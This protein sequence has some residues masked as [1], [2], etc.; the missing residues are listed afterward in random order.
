MDRV[1]LGKLIKIERIKKDMS[2]EEL[3]ERAGISQSTLFF[4]E[5]GRSNT[6]PQTILK[7]LKALG[8]TDLKIEEL[9]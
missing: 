3:S 4:L 5:S 8:V 7:V 1:E 2:Q 6:R 9:I